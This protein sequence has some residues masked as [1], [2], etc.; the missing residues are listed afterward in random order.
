VTI[1]LH[2]LDPVVNWPECSVPGERPSIEAAMRLNPNYPSHYVMARGMAYFAKADFE[3]AANEF[4]AR[5]EQD[6]QAKELALLLASAYA[7]LDRRKE[8][9]AALQLWKPELEL[10]ILPGRYNFR[11]R[12]SY[13]H[14]AVR[15]RLFDGMYI[16]ALPLE[17]TVPSLVE[18]VKGH[19]PFKR[20]SAVKTLG[21][22]G[23]MAE[24]AVP[25]LIAALDDEL[26][27]VRKE[28]VLALAKI[29]PAAKD[30]IP[31]LEAALQE[32]VLIGIYAEKAI[33][34]ITGD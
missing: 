3:L 11:F 6:P 32:G 8:A 1:G 23:P 16:A 24:P 14:R 7:L 30:A 15:E 20:L 2:V 10:S 25:A 27:D 22:F 12:W 17:V 19:D 5:L 26:E 21:L 29:G 28:A 31:A 34:R 4:R 13:E 33:K 9:R 18:M